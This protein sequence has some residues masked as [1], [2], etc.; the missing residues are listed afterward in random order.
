MWDTFVGQPVWTIG[1]CANEVFCAPPIDPNFLIDKIY[2][3]S[4]SISIPCTLALL[5]ALHFV[6]LINDSPWDVELLSNHCE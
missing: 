5:L 6:M 3:N 2:Y 1:Q 4:S